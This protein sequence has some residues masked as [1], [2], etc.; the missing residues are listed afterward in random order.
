MMALDNPSEMPQSRGLTV[1]QLSEISDEEFAKLMKS[2]PEF[3]AILT[4]SLIGAIVC[5]D[6]KH[7]E[8]LL[9][10]DAVDINNPD[11]FGTPLMHAIANGQQ[12]IVKTLLT[13]SR[14]D[15]NAN[16]KSNGMTA[17]ML[18]AV[19]NDVKSIKALL[20]NKDTDVNRQDCLGRTALMYL[21]LPEPPLIDRKRGNS[22]EA[23]KI[24]LEDERVN[25]DIRN[26][27]GLSAED[28]AAKYGF[29][30]IKE[31]LKAARA[32]NAAKQ[33]DS[34]YNSGGIA[35]ANCDKAIKSSGRS[36]L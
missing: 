19:C 34:V 32:V 27:D 20:E 1:G 10:N 4:N 12:N 22:V 6:A 31:F 13:D 36:G 35:A 16:I 17:F 21:T 8:S 23:I 15:V 5:G 9:S 18:A 33:S 28:M 26:N 7:V 24:L 3:Q 30:K 14:I 11:N 25:A 29:I 2:D